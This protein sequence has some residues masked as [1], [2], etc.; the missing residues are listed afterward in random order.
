MTSQDF[1][2]ELKEDIHGFG[3]TSLDDE[4]TEKR[5]FISTGNGEWTDSLEIKFYRE[6]SPDATRAMLIVTDLNL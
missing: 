1:L 3:T 6:S 2:H 5:F 4:I